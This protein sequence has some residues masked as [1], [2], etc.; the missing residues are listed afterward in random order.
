[1]RVFIPK[2]LNTEKQ[3]HFVEN[4]ANWH[5]TLKIFMCSKLEIQLEKQTA[6]TRPMA[7]EHKIQP[8]G[9][10]SISPLRVGL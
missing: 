4:M 7:N 5:I 3:I 9:P 8:L 1:M 10:S 2:A 6:D